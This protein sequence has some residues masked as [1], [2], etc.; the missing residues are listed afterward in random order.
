MI[1]VDNDVDNDEELNTYSR[2]SFLFDGLVCV[3]CVC[4]VNEN[5]DDDFLSLSSFLNAIIVSFPFISS[6]PLKFLQ[7]IYS[8]GWN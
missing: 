2:F 6:C 1:N 3:L 8:F 7:G 5:F 4:F